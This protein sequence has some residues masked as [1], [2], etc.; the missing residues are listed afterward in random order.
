MTLLGR[1]KVKLH[2]EHSIKGVWCVCEPW[3]LPFFLGKMFVL[4]SL[5]KKEEKSFPKKK[6]CFSL[7]K[8]DVEHG[9]KTN[10]LRP[11]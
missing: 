11:N 10:G 4:N 1:K 5:K 7:K 3:C 9:L 6:V 8:K 2:D